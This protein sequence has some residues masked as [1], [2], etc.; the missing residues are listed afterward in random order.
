MKGKLL[1]GIMAL[2]MCF[3]SVAS[4][5]ASS[6][7]TGSKDS[8]EPPYKEEEA[9]VLLKDTQGG[10]SRRAAAASLD[11]DG[12]QVADTCNFKH[13]AKEPSAQ[14]P[15]AAKKSAA[16]KTTTIALVRSEK[17]STEQLLEKLK[18]SG[19]V[20]I[21]APNYQLKACKMP[22]DPY[23]TSQWALKNTGQ[24]DGTPGADLHPERLWDKGT[25]GSSKVVAVVDT[26][27]DY[28]HEDLI[29]N[30][31]V[32]PHQDKLPGKYGYDFVSED[33]EPM[34]DNGHGTH[35]SGIIGASGNNGVGISGI[36]QK[37]KLM[38]LKMLDDDG[39][40]ELYNA[41][42]AYW[43]IS[44]VQDLG[45]DVAAINNSYTEIPE[46]YTPPD[47]PK[48][49]AMNQLFK[50]VMDITGEKGAVS[51]CCAGNDSEDNDRGLIS[52]AGADSPYNIA[53]AAS[54][55]SG[56]L[57]PYSNYGK[58]SV[59]LAAPGSYI[60]STIN[61]P[62]FTPGIYTP[63][64]R[65]QLCDEF[66]DYEEKDSLEP[67]KW[68]VPKNTNPSINYTYTLDQAHF[69]NT[70]KQSLKLQFT[71]VTKGLAFLQIPYTLKEK[72]GQVGTTYASLAIRGGL[73]KSGQP[74]S[75]LVLDMG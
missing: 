74:S 75:I 48:I 1:A 73:S 30:M 52:P 33:A 54:D 4:F 17:L 57:A 66:A 19:Q 70:G 20:E 47:A 28:T 45:V 7:E 32:N 22:D 25:T 9:I 23:V 38:A 51:F 63:A 60:L 39:Y 36:N 6:W 15:S 58:T 71:D 59:D 37:I 29:S 49:K 50:R 64:Q 56:D 65:T 13:A 11:V 43:Y 68:G 12:I 14:S 72:V 67:G 18:A 24:S 53:V 35:C 62:S 41:L 55:P 5:A 69:F 40:G 21:A 26:G 2:M 10:M 3:S 61:E 16:Q 34:D 46:D 27:I 44:D 8:K 42:R 31:W